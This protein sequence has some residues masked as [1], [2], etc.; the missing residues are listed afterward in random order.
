MVNPKR[1]AKKDNQEAE[2]QAVEPLE[3]VQGQVEEPP[4]EV[5]V[6]EPAMKPLDEVLGQDEKAYAAIWKLNGKC[7]GFIRRMSNK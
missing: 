4:V 2:E 7:R 6:E 3:E 5:E 1:Q